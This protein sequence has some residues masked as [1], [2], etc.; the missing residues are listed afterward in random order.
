MKQVKK[1]NDPGLYQK[2]L[3]IVRIG[4]EAVMKAK[5]ENK[6]YGIPEFFYKNGVIYFVKENGELTTEKPKIFQD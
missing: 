5:E 4:N 1:L 6:Q 2:A 3:E